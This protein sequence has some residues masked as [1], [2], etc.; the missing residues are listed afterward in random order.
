[1]GEKTDWDSG[2]RAAAIDE[3]KEMEHV[4]GEYV[5]NDEEL[6]GVILEEEEDEGN[7]ALSRINS[8]EI[9]RPTTSTKA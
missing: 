1:M 6:L 9:P 8:D 4:P 3:I 7:I 2:K 5:D